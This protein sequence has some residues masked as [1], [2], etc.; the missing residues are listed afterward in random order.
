M[1]NRLQHTTT[2]KSIFF[3]LFF[4]SK[5]GKVLSSVA[6]VHSRFRRYGCNYLKEDSLFFLS[7]SFHVSKPNTAAGQSFQRK[8]LC[9]LFSIWLPFLISN[10]CLLAWHKSFNDLIIYHAKHKKSIQNKTFSLSLGLKH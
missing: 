6:L 5:F 4:A 2:S 8:Q 7:A 1:L 10:F 9:T 3:M